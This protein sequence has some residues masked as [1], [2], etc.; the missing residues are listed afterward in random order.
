MIETH[1]KFTNSASFR[2]RVKK[3]VDRIGNT[4]PLMKKISIFLDQWV[5]ENFKTEGGK[6]GGWKPLAAGGRW[7]KGI[8]LDTSASILRDT[9]EMRESFKPF[10]SELNAGIGSLLKRSKAHD[11]G[12]GHLPQ[13]MILP[14][15]EHVMKDVLKKV[16]QHIDKALK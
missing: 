13:R 7:R 5:Q 12:E 11:E 15:D 3:L 14:R 6:V 16:N 2:K 9:G 8:G 1:V 10:S 4:K